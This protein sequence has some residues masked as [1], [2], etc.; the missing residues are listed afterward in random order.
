M[1]SARLFFAVATLAM[2]FLLTCAVT[3]ANASHKSAAPPPP[4]VDGRILIDS[5]DAASKTVVLRYMRD[6]T[7]HTYSFD[8]LSVIKVGDASSD[9]TTVDQIKVGMQVRD[10]VERDSHTLDSIIVSTA[11]PAPTNPPPQ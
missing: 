3:T 7:T 2:A 9:P 10:Y 6:G 11:D 4:P 5:V 8:D 1:K